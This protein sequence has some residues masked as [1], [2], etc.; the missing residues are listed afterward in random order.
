MHFRNAELQDIPSLLKLYTA[1]ATQGTL[2]RSDSEI[3]V[4]YIQGFIEKGITGGLI[5]VAEHPERP[6][7]LVGEIHAVKTGVTIYDH[8]LTDLTFAVHPD[9]QKKGL[10]RSLL[11]L[12]LDEVA[13][14]RPDI[15]KVELMVQESQ[16]RAISLFQSLGFL[17][18]G[19]LEMRRRN[20]D[21]SYEAD[22]AMG[23]Q[24]PTFEFDGTAG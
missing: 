16:A 12:F 2:V 6:H 23:W 3:T 15:G 4:E 1:V 18:E 9:F 13:R 7:E 22:I 10:G 11:T 21:L 5:I 20:A 14:N 24:N 19:R 17:I 8:V